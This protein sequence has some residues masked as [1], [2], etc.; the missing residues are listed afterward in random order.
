MPK[1]CG[2]VACSILV[3]APVPFG[4]RS[5]WD[6]VGVGS[7]GEGF[8]TKVLVWGQGLTPMSVNLSLNLFVKNVP[9]ILAARQAVLMILISNETSHCLR[10]AA[11]EAGHG[12]FVI[13]DPV[14]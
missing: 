4:F 2:T 13:Y 10:L 8:G 11:R 1:C 6:L 5:Y 14:T 3:S 12:P 9:L 7:R